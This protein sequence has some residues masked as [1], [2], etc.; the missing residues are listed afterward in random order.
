MV[1]NLLNCLR[2]VS[3]LL[4][5]EYTLLEFLVRCY[6]PGFW[7]VLIGRIHN[8]LCPILAFWLG[9]NKSLPCFSTGLFLIQP[10][11]HLE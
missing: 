6:P 9:L 1:S 3:V 8:R 2:A 11:D 4:R 5:S 10:L 7:A